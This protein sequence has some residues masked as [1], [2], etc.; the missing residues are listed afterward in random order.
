MLVFFLMIAIFNGDWLQW[1]SIWMSYRMDKW[2]QITG[3]S[4]ILDL[5]YEFPIILL[6]LKVDLPC[7]LFFFTHWSVKEH[8]AS[9][10]DLEGNRIYNRQSLQLKNNGFRI[11]GGRQRPIPSKCHCHNFVPCIVFTWHVHF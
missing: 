9:I 6:L 11:Q 3:W 7:P 1:I 2:L 5:L 8:F 10:V 4:F